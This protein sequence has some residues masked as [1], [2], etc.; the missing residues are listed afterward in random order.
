MEEG[1][2]KTLIALSLVVFLQTQSLLSID[3]SQLFSFGSRKD[4]LGIPSN[5]DFNKGHKVANICYR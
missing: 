5:N 4:H 3:T 2:L 1:I